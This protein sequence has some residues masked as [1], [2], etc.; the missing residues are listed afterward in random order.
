MT[1]FVD[2]YFID[3]KWAFSIVLTEFI[4]K[5]LTLSN[6][7]WIAEHIQILMNISIIHSEVDPSLFFFL[8]S[9]LRK[10]LIRINF[11]RR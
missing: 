4:K 8:L 3:Q 1:V 11:E 9:I 10:L 5:L 7:V 2:A 6:I